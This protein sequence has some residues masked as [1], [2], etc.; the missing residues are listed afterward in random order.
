MS[1]LV[2]L[3]ASL[4]A[5]VPEIGI[6]VAERTGSKTA[7][8]ALLQA[9]PRLRALCL[10]TVGFSQEELESAKAELAE[11]KVWLYQGPLIISE[12]K[13]VAVE[14]G[15][16]PT[17]PCAVY[18]TAEFKKT[19]P[20]ASASDVLWVSSTKYPAQIRRPVRRGALEKARAVLPEEM[21][22]L[23]Q[24]PKAVSQR[25]VERGTFVGI[26]CTQGDSSISAIVMV[27]KKGLPK[28]ALAEQGA[29]R[30]LDVIDPQPRGN[31]HHLI[32]ARDLAAG[33]R[34]EL[35]KWDS[36]QEAMTRVDDAI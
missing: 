10:D 12:G 22:K 33:R 21:I 34:V 2:L 35:W 1:G 25:G 15:F 6:A 20:V 7:K 30:L 24:T 13:V 18:A 4:L 9:D 26:I 3:A 8:L 5:A 16:S 17:S 11:Q 27:P 19:V 31:E 32:L 29:L 28:V 14:T 23:C 36:S